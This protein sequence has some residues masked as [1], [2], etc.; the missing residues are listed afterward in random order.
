[1]RSS[2][3]KSFLI[4]LL[5][6]KVIVLVVLAIVLHSKERPH[7]PTW[8]GFRGGDTFSYFD[9]IET[10]LRH[11]T[12]AAD[13][14][15][16]E[17]YA[18][19]MPGYGVVYA[20]FRLVGLSADI[21]QSA[22]VV[23]QL[24]LSLLAFWVLLEV[25][26][27]VFAD[28]RLTKLVGIVLALST[29]T[30]VFDFY[31]LTESFSTSTFVF[32]LYCLWRG[33]TTRWYLLPAGAFLT[34]VVFLR[35]FMGA[36]FGVFALWLLLDDWQRNSRIN[37]RNMLA[38]LALLG[39][40]LLLA[41]GWWIA[42][43]YPIYHRPVPLQGDV[44]AGYNVP[45]S[46]AFLRYYIGGWGGDA[47]FWTPDAPAHWFTPEVAAT[48]ALPAFPAYAYAP[49][50]QLDSLRELRRLFLLTSD[51]TRPRALRTQVDAVLLPRIK[52]MSADYRA[53]HPWR[54]YVL[55]PLQLCRKFLF[56]NGA[57]RISR[58]PFA[59]ASLLGKVV[60]S[61]YAALFLV[62]VVVGLLGTALLAWQRRLWPLLVVALPVF[63]IVLFPVLLRSI[64]YRH[65]VPAYPF[66]AIAACYAILHMWRWLRQR[67]GAHP[68][69]TTVVV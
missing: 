18:G 7:D 21:A 52:A 41:D 53:A 57:Y 29:Y 23:A 44:M 27:A 22:V 36:F 15:R 6:L 39:L 9:P 30:A 8:L 37:W 49:H 1:M 58:V 50:Y 34:W 40:P 45:W 67:L 63:I 32:A 16:I 60:R 19:R 54:F 69:D 26:Q 56:H 31:L 24:L 2:L 38:G 61:G 33:R 17:T 25:V 47:V 43:N 35:P 5:G 13:L 4:A 46:D 12:Y 3:S 51:T 66:M 28:M 10:W 20:A 42:R 11:G 55:A 48:N 14:D 59:K 68:A 65:F 62:V 64:E